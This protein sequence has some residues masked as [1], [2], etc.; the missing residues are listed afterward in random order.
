MLEELKI[1]FRKWIV[2]IIRKIFGALGFKIERINQENICNY[3][4]YF[5]DKE[6]EGVKFKFYIGDS[7]G[8][9]WYHIGTTDPPWLEMRFIKERLIQ[10]GDIVFE[11]GSHHGCTA[12][13]LSNWVGETG[14]VVAFEPNPSNFEI[15]KINLSINSVRNVELVKSAVGRNSDEVLLDISS[16]NSSILYDKSNNKS[17]L[18]KSISLD[19]LEDVTPD[20]IKIDVEGFEIE[21]LIGAKRILKN[22]PKLAIEIHVEQLIKYNYSVSEIFD[23]IN[24][25][26]YDFWIQWEDNEYPVPYKFEKPINKRVH[27]FGLP[28]L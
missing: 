15:A 8:K 7:D 25:D 5:I 26:N 11:C 9:K 1:K 12:L 17:N 22:K 18:V 6:L 21:V 4:P 14:K 27:I 10:K 28:K 23:L 13:L 3:F 19:S 2:V 20:V 24:I 16:S